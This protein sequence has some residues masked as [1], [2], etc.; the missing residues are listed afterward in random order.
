MTW[1][2]LGGEN[3]WVHAH[4]GVKTHLTGPADERMVAQRLVDPHP[5]PVQGRV[6]GVRYV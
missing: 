6:D 1:I 4:T 3:R 2:F 5:R